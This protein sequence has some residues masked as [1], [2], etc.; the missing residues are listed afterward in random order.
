VFCAE[1]SNFVEINRQCGKDAG[2]KVYKRLS[3]IVNDT[4]NSA[5]SGNIA[6][7]SKGG[8]IIGYI[9]GI[10]AVEAVDLLF[11]MLYLVKEFS[12]SSDIK[13]LPDLI[14]NAGIYTEKKRTN[15][16]M[17]IE[18]ARRIMFQGA[19]GKTGHVAFLRNSDQI[20]EDKDF[21]RRGRLKE[22]L[23]SVIS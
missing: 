19:D 17:N 20:V 2:D 11:K 21:D 22:G 13:S 5:G 23:V 9:N 8:L 4:L 12:L 18:T 14:F 3:E 16:I 1:L 7:R 6:M 10:T 15:S